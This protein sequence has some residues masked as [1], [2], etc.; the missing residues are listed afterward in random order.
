MIILAFK[1]FCQ[2]EDSNPKINS[3]F[4]LLL[5]KKAE[6]PDFTSGFPLFA[7]RQV[8]SLY[9]LNLSSTYLQIFLIQAVVL[10]VRYRF[11][12]A[13]IC[14]AYT[15]YSFKSCS[16]NSCFSSVQRNSGIVTL[17]AATA[18]PFFRIGLAVQRIISLDSSFS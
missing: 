10:P 2:A 4:V 7:V 16:I 12:C 11:I 9:I 13:A 15:A 1:R 6:N 5:Q 8:S 17:M 18:A 14:P 3:R